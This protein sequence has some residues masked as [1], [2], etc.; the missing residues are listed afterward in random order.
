MAEIPRTVGRHSTACASLS[1]AH[2]HVPLSC[3]GLVP[4]ARDHGFKV[5][6]Q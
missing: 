5:L 3:C 4:A 2:Q 1:S 6:R